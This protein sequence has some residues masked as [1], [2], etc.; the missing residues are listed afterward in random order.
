MNLETHRRATCTALVLFCL[1]T[2]SQTPLRGQEAGAAKGLVIHKHSPSGSD[3]LADATE[4]LTVERFP[5][6]TNISPVDGGPQ[7]RIL[8]DRV[9]E[10]I[11]YTDLTGG[12]I[13]TDAQIAELESRPKALG[14]LA[15]K[16]PKAHDLL[17]AE[18]RRINAALQMLDQ[19]KVLV[20]GRWQDKS[21]MSAPSTATGET[22][23]VWLD[24][25]QTRTYTSV[26]VTGQDPDALRIMH[27]G[28]AASI[29]FEQLS[30]AD[31][32]KYGFDA[33][34]A[35]EFR[36]QKEM[37]A[38]N[39]PAQMP[40]EAGAP[41]NS[42]SP[43]TGVEGFLAEIGPGFSTHDN[44]SS[45]KKQFFAGLG[46]MD[47]FYTAPKLEKDKTYAID[48]LA[49][50]SFGIQQRVGGVLLINDI[51][52]SPCAILNC[53]PAELLEGTRLAQG[54]RAWAIG[55]YLG[56]REFKMN[57]G[58]AR[59]FPLFT[60]SLLAWVTEDGLALLN[61]AGGAAGSDS[62]MSTGVGEKTTASDLFRANPTS[63]AY[64][65]DMLKKQMEL[66]G[67]PRVI[68]L[69]LRAVFLP[70]ELG[71]PS[72]SGVAMVQFASPQ[73][74]VGPD[75]KWQTPWMRS[76]FT[77]MS[78]AG[79]TKIELKDEAGNMVGDQWFT[80]GASGGLIYHTTQLSSEGEISVEMQSSEEAMAEMIKDL[81]R[82]EQ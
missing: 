75:N 44:E 10:V 54:D 11:E 27:S 25:G 72:G 19:G 77:V 23:V 9:A 12:T 30:E 71:N 53:E 79:S 32:K 14:V 34:K 69:W 28:G 21:E 47:S 56:D 2:G 13:T 73:A 36:K 37:A 24:D 16:F 4:Y 59:T 50:Q 43:L 26:K 33:A 8:N 40:T 51:N 68:N 52:D 15:K 35:E 41:Q 48:S 6:V 60:V 17:A 57:F 18:A 55:T 42:D 67:E 20:A 46:A 3:K 5:R 80:I 74:T 45:I 29:P 65:G 61:F 1:A 78:E 7:M 62:T 39:R 82:Q 81:K 31:Q 66:N 63:W 49:G 64:T 22:L 38:A 76:P 70:Q 58:G